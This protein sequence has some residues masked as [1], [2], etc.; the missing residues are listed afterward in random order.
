MVLHTSAIMNDINIQYVH[1][2][3]SWA[4]FIIPFALPKIVQ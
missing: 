1:F 3:C 2:W 4:D